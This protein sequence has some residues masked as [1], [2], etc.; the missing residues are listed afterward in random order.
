[1]LKLVTHGLPGYHG[2]SSKTGT[3]AELKERCGVPVSKVVGGGTTQHRILLFC[4]SVYTNIQT[5]TKSI[6]LT[7]ILKTFEE[8]A[9]SLAHSENIHTFAE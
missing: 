9:P 8:N 7:M 1:M 2:N 5:I 4:K 3:F 6:V